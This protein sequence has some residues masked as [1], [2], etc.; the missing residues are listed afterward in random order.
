MVK[1]SFILPIYNEE[2]NIPILYR[3]LSKVIASI[4]CDYELVCI[5][6]KGKDNSLQVLLDLQQHDKKI[7]IIEF[8]RN[9][10]HEMAVK[11]G[12]DIVD[13]DYVVMMDCDM[14]DPPH[15]IEKMYNKMQGGYDV[16]YAKR[17]KRA[18][19]DG[20]F[21]NTATFLFYRML[22]RLTNLYIPEDTGNFRIYTKQIND[23]VKNFN[24]QSRFLRGLFAWVGYKQSSVEYDRGDRLHGQTGYGFWKL[25]KL[26]LDGVF[27]F[28][29]KPLKMA[30][31]FGFLFSGVGF[32]LGLFFVIMKF[33]NPNL[34]VSGITTLIVLIF[35]IGGIQLIIL[36][37]IGEYIGRIYNETKGRPLYIVK[38]IYE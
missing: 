35:L 23:L 8:S 19:K 27:S 18:K 33:V 22:N 9:F 2:K 30:T 31:L 26:A 7:K 37:M 36:G 13:G 32:L 3:E 38:K 11:A 17:G 5:D 12:M 1:I 10:G 14:Q 28:S 21:K 15:L 29:D 34:Y 20:M 25:L 4:G 6:D 16:V 24:E